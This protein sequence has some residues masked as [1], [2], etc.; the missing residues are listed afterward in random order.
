M[1]R[2]EKGLCGRLQYS[3][4]DARFVGVVTIGDLNMLP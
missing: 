3:I 4:F 2:M 1:A